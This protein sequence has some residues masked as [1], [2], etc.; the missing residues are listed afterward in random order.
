M[1][2]KEESTSGGLYAY[3]GIQKTAVDIENS[4][5]VIDEEMFEMCHLKIGLVRKMTNDIR[6]GILETL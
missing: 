3:S 6:K 2:W 5:S 1:Q 4:R